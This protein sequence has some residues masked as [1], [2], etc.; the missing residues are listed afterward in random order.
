M[1]APRVGSDVENPH[2]EQYFNAEQTTY[3]EHLIQSTLSHIQM[4]GQAG[5]D[6][7]A[8]LLTAAQQA[9]QHGFAN[10]WQGGGD[11]WVDDTP[12]WRSFWEW[13]MGLATV[14]GAQ[15]DPDPP[16]PNGLAPEVIV[17]PTLASLVASFPANSPDSTVS[18]S[19][20]D[21]DLGIVTP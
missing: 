21:N 3:L 16:F 15:D 6:W 12:V 4:L 13:L 1:A 7:A 8:G 19:S 9:F 14:Y 2:L 11:A 10:V 18:P 20:Q 17:P 5:G